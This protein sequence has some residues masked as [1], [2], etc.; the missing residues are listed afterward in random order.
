MEYIRHQLTRVN[1]ITGHDERQVTATD[2]G[3]HA[4]LL[5]EIQI[6]VASGLRDPKVDGNV[7]VLGIKRS[8]ASSLR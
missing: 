5:I 8:M 3:P 2:R 6:R 7:K 1:G 4:H